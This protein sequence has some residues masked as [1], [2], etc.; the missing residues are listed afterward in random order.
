[1]RTVG[2][3]YEQCTSTSMMKA[4]RAIQHERTLTRDPTPPMKAPPPGTP[5]DCDARGYSGERPKT[6]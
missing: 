1:M 5:Y 2:D 3:D 4:S 6:V